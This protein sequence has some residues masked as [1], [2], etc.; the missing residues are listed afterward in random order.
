M[1]VD[2]NGLELMIMVRHYESLY[3]YGWMLKRMDSS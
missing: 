1:K 2:K 3:K